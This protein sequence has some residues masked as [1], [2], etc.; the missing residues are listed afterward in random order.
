MSQHILPNQMS[1]SGSVQHNCENSDTQ[2]NICHIKLSSIRDLWACILSSFLRSSILSQDLPF[3]KQLV[4]S[5]S[6]LVFSIAH[7]CVFLKMKEEK[8]LML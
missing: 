6:H 3:S 8:K 1:R 4:T 5:S 2:T 7:F